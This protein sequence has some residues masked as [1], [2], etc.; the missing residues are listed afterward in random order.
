MLVHCQSVE[1]ICLTAAL[2]AWRPFRYDKQMQSQLSGHCNSLPL[3]SNCNFQHVLY[4]AVTS[5]KAQ[6]ACIIS[7]ALSFLD[8]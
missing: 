1:Q 8:T 7:A 3:L 6:H 5:S 2:T 4:N